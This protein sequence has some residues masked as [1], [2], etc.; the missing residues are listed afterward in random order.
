MGKDLSGALEACCEAGLLVES[1]FDDF[2]PPEGAVVCS[3]SRLF[4][5]GDLF[6][7]VPGEH[8]DGHSFL[9]EAERRGACALLVQR[10][11]QTS[12]PYALLKD[13]RAG[14][15]FFAA[16]LAGYPLRQ[17]QAFAVTG[18]NGKTTSSLL[19]RHLIQASGKKCG[20]LGTL[21]NDDGKT[22]LEAERTTLESSALQSFFARMVANGCEAMV[23]ETSSHGLAQ[24]RVNGCAYDGGIFTNLSPEHLDFHGTMDDYFDAKKRLAT[25]YLKKD[26]PLALCPHTPWGAKMA[27]CASHPVTW[28]FD[29]AVDLLAQSANLG[30][31]GS[32]FDLTW[33]GKSLGRW[34]VPLV[35]QFNLENT[36]GVLALLFEKGYD[37][38]LLKEALPS[39]PSVPGR[40]NRFLLENGVTVVVDFAHTAKALEAVLGALRP[41]AR[42]VVSVF[43]H[44]GGRYQGARPLLG[45]VADRYAD[46]IILTSD[47]SRDEDPAHIAQQISEGITHKDKV[48]QCLDRA[49]A[50]ALALDQA[51]EGDVVVITGKGAERTIEQAGVKRPF[52]DEEQVRLW[53]QKKGVK[54][55]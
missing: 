33:K 1:A 2:T 47:N 18:S 4:R 34:S 20:L 40:M 17:L 44:G 22:C 36:L 49:E 39:A 28:G 15:G 51:H 30:P 25:C 55:Q 45:E 35:G 14:M 21:F 23:M 27:D 50:I 46:R 16:A 29:G 8:F 37:P 10:P 41:L 13:V 6:A 3:D 7:C 43:G 31:G 11:V 54:L 19:L 26:A 38:E 24:G 32:D 48:S 9:P 5:S 12:L 52:N 53:A 42:R